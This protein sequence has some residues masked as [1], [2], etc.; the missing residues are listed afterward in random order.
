[1]GLEDI[2]QKQRVA[3]I[4]DLHGEFVDEKA[5]KVTLSFLRDYQPSVLVINGDLVDFYPISN[6]DKNP[7]RK[8]NVQEE[9]DKANGMLRQMRKVV[10][11]DCKMYYI[12]GNHENRLQRYLWKNPELESVR[13]LS[14]P[15]MMSLK[16]PKVEFIKTDMDYWKSTDGSLE[17]GDIHV[18]HGDNRLNGAS[19]SKYS[20]YSAKNTMMNM[21]RSILM[22][23]VHRLGLVYHR[24]KAGT[25]VGLEGGCLC[26][27]PPTANWQQ[28][29]V[30]FD[31]L[32]D[33]RTVNHRL[34]HINDGVLYADGKRYEGK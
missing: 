3:V 6:W 9:C 32:G 8:G 30:T 22:G 24:S 29:F 23:H 31:V 14:L 17:I 19:T 16:G 12:E 10:G 11:K 13:S 27:V 5:Y 7:A 28:G 33:K 18:T 34:H 20:G 1:M 21:Q 4:S 26:Q 25:L 2:V 15:E